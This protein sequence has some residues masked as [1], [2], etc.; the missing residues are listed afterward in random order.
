LKKLCLTL[1]A[2]L[3]IAVSLPAASGCSSVSDADMPIVL[4]SDFGSEDYR[5]PQLKGIIYNTSPGATLIDASH[6][7]PSFDIFTG[8]FI[9]DIAA[10]EFPED[11]VFI[12]VIAPYA[13][14]ET[15]YIVLV[16]EKDQFF[17]LPDNGL[18]TYVARD[19]GIKSIYRVTNQDLFDDP[20]EEL[21]AERTQGTVGALIASGY[22]P[23][24]VGP[25]LSD[26]SMLDT[27]GGAISGDELSGTV[28]Y[29]D[30]FGNCI[31]DISGS[32]AGEFGVNRGDGIRVITDQGTID[33]VY[34]AIYSDVPV[35]DEVVF[36]NNNIDLL[37]L[38]LNMDDFA[39]AYNMGTGMKVEI[40]K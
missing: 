28:V 7:V 4:L 40:V 16:T 6:D 29:I 32:T 26:P 11:V 37:Q 19:T 10:Q 9:L 24:D 13:Q 25:P 36:V 33:A 22:N 23:E 39:A 35:G 17:V 21:S 27:Q 38:S 30:H 2:L 20:L 8:A 18:L 31:T 15:K 1:A 5:V 14:T 12:A 34:G 3:L